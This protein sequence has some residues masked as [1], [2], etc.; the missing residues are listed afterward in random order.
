MS[1]CVR[2]L[3]ASIR[4][5]IEHKSPSLSFL[6]ARHKV[7]DKEP[8]SR[9]QKQPATI[10]PYNHI[11][12]VVDDDGDNGDSGDKNRDW[13]NLQCNQ[14]ELNSMMIHFL[15]AHRPYSLWYAHK[16]RSLCV[17]FSSACPHVPRCTRTQV[18]GFSRS[19]HLRLARAPM[20]LVSPIIITNDINL[21]E[22]FISHTSTRTSHRRVRANPTW[23][24]TYSV[25]SLNLCLC[26]HACNP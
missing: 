26:T 11:M 5:R 12:W 19:L 4:W 1:V 17:C 3:R 9:E 22:M 23:T 14:L 6:I 25:L 16:M 10:M 21:H 15:S 8:K 24:W 20:T 18:D 2:R 7:I 13:H